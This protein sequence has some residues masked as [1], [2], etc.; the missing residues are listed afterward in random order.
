M[1]DWLICCRLV[2]YRLI[3][4]RVIRDGLFRSRLLG[5]WFCH[6]RL[7]GRFAGLLLETG[8]AQHR[9]S[10]G[11]FE[12]HGG[13]QT[14][15]GTSCTG[16]RPHSCRTTRAL[17]FTLFAMFGVVLELLIVKE[18]LFARSEGELCPTIYTFEYPIGKFHFC[19]PA[20]RKHT[21]GGL[22][23]ICCRPGFPVLLIGAY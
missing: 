17:G 12:G 6:G 9:S 5:D 15:F 11:G 3:F 23:W 2:F 13:F 10:L 4:Y 14:A 21:E 22:R 8:A 1:G 19:F 20:T 7:V 16:F 18:N